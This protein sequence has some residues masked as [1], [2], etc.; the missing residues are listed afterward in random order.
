M[1]DCTTTDLNGTRVTAHSHYRGIC[2]AYPGPDGEIVIDGHTLSRSLESW[3]RDHRR[4]AVVDPEE[5][6]R[7]P[8]PTCGSPVDIDW[9]EITEFSQSQR[10][11]IAGR[12]EC[13]KNRR[14]DIRAAYA[15]LNW[16]A[17]LTDDDRVWLRR[18]AR[19]AKEQA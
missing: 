19:L 11:F 15:E 2:H 13:P 12:I 18:Q 3:L 16:P 9:C 14:H 1:S 4:E 5:E 6:Y 8:C 7:P 10:Q 17:G